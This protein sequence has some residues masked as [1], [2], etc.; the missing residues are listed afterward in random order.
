LL[1]ARVFGFRTLES[2][3]FVVRLA[4]RLP[5]TGR[6]LDQERFGDPLLADV[7]VS[8]S[9]PGSLLD[10]TGA[11]AATAAG[12]RRAAQGRSRARRHGR[13]DWGEPDRARRVPAARAQRL[14]LVDRQCHHSVRFDL[15]RQGLDWGYVGDAGWDPVW[16]T[17]APVTPAAFAEAI[18]QALNPVACVVV[19]SPSYTGQCADVAGIVRAVRACAP[20]AFVHVDQ[21]WG[22][23]CRGSPSS[24]GPRRWC[25]VRTRRRS[26]SISR[27]A[28]SSPG[29]RCSRKSGS[30]RRS[31]TP[32]TRAA[33]RRARAC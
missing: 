18:R 20:H 12:D 33:L 7:S 16:E 24:R 31:C 10:Q 9:A 25:A 19:T 4:H 28:L 14:F 1:R 17:S 26:R 13:V 22:S 8:W 32:R 5:H 11:I 29:R 21:A 30:R 2:A 23:T 6:L 15:T 27:P 3:R